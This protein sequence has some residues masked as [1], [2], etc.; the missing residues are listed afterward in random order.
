VKCDLTTLTPEDLSDG[1][2]TCVVGLAP[3]KPAEFIRYQIRVRLNF[4]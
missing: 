4:R 3:M 2:L 1:T